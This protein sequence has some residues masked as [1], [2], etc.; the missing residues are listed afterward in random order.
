MA[1]VLDGVTR[2]L[3]IATD[4]EIERTGRGLQWL[5]ALERRGHVYAGTVPGHVKARRRAKD[6]VAKASRKTNRGR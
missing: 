1:V 6:R 4:E 2:L 5:T 3:G